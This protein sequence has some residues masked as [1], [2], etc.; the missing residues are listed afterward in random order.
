MAVRK[1]MQALDKSHA[2]GYNCGMAT[3]RDEVKRLQAQEG[4]SNRQMA[5]R[6]GISHGM[7][8][9]VRDGRRQP[10]RKVI[11]GLKR[12]YPSLRLDYVLASEATE[13]RCGSSDHA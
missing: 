6:L 5:Q 3:I 7:L 12:A 11:L 13:P 1:P 10:G 8:R 2:M 9:A 4:L